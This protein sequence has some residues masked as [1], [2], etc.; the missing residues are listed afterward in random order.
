M[1]QPSLE[2]YDFY[3]E[4]IAACDT[5]ISR[6]YGMTRPDRVSGELPVVPD[7][8]RPAHSKNAPKDARELR[9]HLY[10]ING[11]EVS[12]VAGFGVSLAQSVTMEVGRKV[13]EKFP[14][15]KH[16]S[17]WL[18]ARY[19]ITKH[20]RPRTERGRRSAWRRHR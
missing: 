8:Q 1:L 7:K 5:E 13:G 17:A 20:S 16:F 4:K 6:Q 15:E 10:R 3:T 14:T 19:C 11:V 9:E 12:L 18:G 2:L